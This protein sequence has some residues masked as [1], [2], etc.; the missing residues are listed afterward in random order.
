MKSFL[1]E[2]ALWGVL[3]AGVWFALGYT[4]GPLDA[5]ETPP[6]RTRSEN[7]GAEAGPVPVA[8][9]WERKPTGP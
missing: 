9:Y 8:G 1:A 7:T 6:E 2:I 5:P 4:L 3:G